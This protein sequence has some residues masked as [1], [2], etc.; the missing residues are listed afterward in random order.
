MHIGHPRMALE[1][2]RL[3]AVNI[4]GG[5]GAPGSAD[6]FFAN[7]VLLNHFDSGAFAT[8]SSSYG[9]TLSSSVGSVT[10]D[11]TTFKWGTG[12]AKFNG[13]SCLVVNGNSPAEFNFSTGDWTIEC[14]VYP[15][16]AAGVQSLIIQRGA[17][18]QAFWLLLDTGIPRLQCNQAGSTVINRVGSSALSLNSWHHVAATRSGDIF[19]LLADGAL[20]STGGAT[21][22]LDYVNTATLAFGAY[23]AGGNY[24]N[25]NLDDVRITKG[26]ARYTG[27]YTVPTGPF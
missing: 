2:L 20:L 12:S 26:V 18:N 3:G 8:D 6:P 15:T 17:T 24:L 5:G 23:P 27:A 13:A 11:T 22:S 7:V 1:G 19:Y 16:S 25:G 21:G 9:H 10:N 14:W 4:V